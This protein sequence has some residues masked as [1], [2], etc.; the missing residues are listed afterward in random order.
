M[1]WDEVGV[2]LRQGLPSQRLDL[3]VAEILQL[4]MGTLHE[5]GILGGGFSTPLSRAPLS[6]DAM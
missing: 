3:R 1:H 6:L 5:D 4:Y 2:P